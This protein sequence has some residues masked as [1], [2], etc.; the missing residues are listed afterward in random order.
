MLLG[1]ERD[2]LAV[3]GDAPA[4]RVDRDAHARHGRLVPGE[5]R[6]TPCTAR[7]PQQRAHACQQLAHAERLGDVV[8]GPALEA[9]HAVG[10][11]GACGQHQDGR[12]SIRAVTAD[13]LT[14]RDAVEPRQHEI[15]HDQVEAAFLRDMERLFTVADDRAVEVGQLQMEADEI[16]DRLFV[17]DDQDARATRRR[18]RRP[19][20]VLHRRHACSLRSCPP[21]RPARLLSGAK[22]VAPG[23]YV[24]APES[25]RWR[26][27]NVT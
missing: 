9:Q 26:L 19:R 2:R 24:N 6:S 10:L 11:F 17:L 20:E 23:D 22:T 15:E 1:R 7:A 25:S 12:L 14:Q 5:H 16:A 3:D 8:I 4:R 27:P 18:H 21:A 13:R